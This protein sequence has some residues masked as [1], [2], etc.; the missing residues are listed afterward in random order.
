MVPVRGSTHGDVD[1]ILGALC[2]DGFAK[3]PGLVTGEELVTV[4]HHAARLLEGEGLPFREYRSWAEAGEWRSRLF[5]R[6][7]QAFRVDF[8]GLSPELDTVIE[9]VLARPAVE[10]ALERILG[11]GH[12]LWYA[13]IRR[14]RAGERLGLRLHHDIAGEIGLVLL[15]RDAPDKDGGMV[16]LKGSHRWPRVLDPFPFIYPKR[17]RQHVV[18]ATGRAGDAYLFSNSTWHGRLPARSRDDVSL[19]LTFL[20]AAQPRRTRR[21]QPEIVDQL[22]SRLR[23]LLRPSDALPSTGGGIPSGDPLFQDLVDGRAA[24]SPLSPWHAA[25][26]AAGAAAPVTRIV[27]WARRAAGIE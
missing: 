6:S 11:P 2:R 23:A 27:R 20:P 13:T 14:A 18:G 8:L 4:Q 22:G 25:R 3:L 5:V 24:L 16:W 9:S 26:L 12:H 15:L 7:S 17:F 21:P 1:S 19:V 10:L